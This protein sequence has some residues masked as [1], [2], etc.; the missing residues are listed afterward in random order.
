MQKQQLLDWFW[1]RERKFTV[2]EIEQLLERVKSF[3]CG[4]IDSYLDNHVE[5]V[6]EEWLAENQLKEVH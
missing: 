5:K 4:A 2:T 3:N 1:K 6:F